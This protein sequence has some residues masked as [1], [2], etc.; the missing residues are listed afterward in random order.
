M[1]VHLQSF[2]TKGR[3][4]DDRGMNRFKRGLNVLNLYYVECNGTHIL[5]V[6]G[7]E[8]FID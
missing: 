6:R 5:D 1:G 7:T 4:L 3:L 8:C 2:Q